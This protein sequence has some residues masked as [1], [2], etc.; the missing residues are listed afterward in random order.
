MPGSNEPYTT[1]S[2]GP[3]AMA[4]KLVVTY[5]NGLA[6]AGGIAGVELRWLA[7]RSVEQG[8]RCRSASG[9]GIL[10][11]GPNPSPWHLART[12]GRGHTHPVR[13]G[14]FVPTRL[15]GKPV[16]QALFIR[17]LRTRESGVRDCGRE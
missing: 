12:L 4:A 10:K 9:Q 5:L 6:E 2:L 7:K 13:Q 17:L 15:M 16:A 11:Q 1:A 3:A 8:D 14:L